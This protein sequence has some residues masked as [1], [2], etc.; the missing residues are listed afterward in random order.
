MVVVVTC[1]FADDTVVYREGWMNFI[2]DERE[3]S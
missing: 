1:L 2:V 3:G